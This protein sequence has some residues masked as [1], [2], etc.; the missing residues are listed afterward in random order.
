VKLTPEGEHWRIHP[1]HLMALQ[2]KASCFDCVV[3]GAQVMWRTDVLDKMEDPWLPENPS[4]LSCRHSDGIF[5]EKLMAATRS[6]V[7]HNLVDVLVTH[8]VTSHSTYLRP[9]GTVWQKHPRYGPVRKEEPAIQ[10]D[11]ITVED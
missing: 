10:N 6:G 11:T 8:R 7:M 9:Y 5:L 1:N 4:I 3:D 2:P